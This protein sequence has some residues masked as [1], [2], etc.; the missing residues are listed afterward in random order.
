MAILEGTV[1]ATLAPWQLAAL[2]LAFLWSGFVRSGLGFGGAALTLPL[3]LLVIDDPL[4][5]LPAIGC[6]LLVFSL[7]TVATRLENVDW[8]YLRTLT[9]AL[10]LPVAAGLVGLLN[11]SPTLLSALVYTVT[12]VY[13]LMYLLDRG[14][15]SNSRVSDVMLIAL[16]GYVSGVSLTGAPLIVAV[17]ARRLP[18]P[19]LR[20]TLFVV[21]IVLVL[22]KLGTFVAAGVDLQ[23]RLFALT[24]PFVALGHVLGLRLHTRLVAGG[25]RG[26]RRLV[27][28]GLTA[29]SS[30]G[31]LAVL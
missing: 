20:D 7:L 24:L 13:G 26:F 15:V 27:G 14:I 8:R 9:L 12:L 6:Q 3:L 19:R 23:W 29:V 11:L 22:A 17:G 2:A 21:W 28:A 10:A 25:A 1:W 4:V 31:L 5:F 18:P 16:G 30:V